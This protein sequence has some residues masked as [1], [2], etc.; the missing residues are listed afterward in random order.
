MKSVSVSNTPSGA[1]TIVE[2]DLVIVGSGAGGLSAAI[3]AKKHGLDVV[4]IE[5]ED[6]FGGTT[7]LSGGVLWIPG[8]AHGKKAGIQDSLEEARTYM[9]NETGAFFDQKA[10]DV[11]L[12]NGPEMVDFFE[13]ETCVK[14]IPTLYP[15]YHPN[16]G[17]GVD[18]GRSIL[19]EPFDIR[20]L[21]ADMK[22][23]RPPLKTITFI[24]MMFNSSNADLK[25][26]FQATKSLRSALYV[27]KRLVSHMR[28]LMLYGRGTKVTSGNALAARLAKAALDLGIPIY[29]STPAKALLK[30][31]KLVVGVK[32]F[33]SGEAALKG[34]IL[35]KARSGV[36][37]ACG[38]F[39]QDKKRIETIYPHLTQGGE[40]FSPTPAG[41]CGDGIALAEAVGGKFEARFKQA[42]AWMP[43][44]KVPYADGSFGA[45]PHL[46]DRYKPGVIGVLR[47]GRRFTNESN[48]YHDVGEAMIA[49]CEKLDGTSGETAMWL[50]CDQPTIKKY[51]LGYAKPAPVPLRGLIKRG[52]LV[53]GGSLA[54][55]AA[56][57]G[58]DAQ[59]LEATV[60]QYNLGAVKGEDPE[61]GRGTTT[62]NRYLADAS[63]QPNPCVAPIAQGPFYALK[64]VMGDLGTF[65]GLRTSAMG[66]VLDENSQVIAGLYAVGNDRESVMGGNYPAAGITLG[67]NMTFGYVTARHIA[68][69]GSY[70]KQELRRPEMSLVE[71]SDSYRD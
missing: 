71:R 65:D 1:V 22:R 37:L 31:G 17:G 35:F 60:H 28:E 7:A 27:A 9:R 30:D 70:V 29:T 67:P 53:K 69:I 54:E 11:F 18:I 4:V 52:Y 64:V 41:N 46:L 16:V 19:A 44:S 12:K 33:G 38:G 14:F 24:G 32:A 55:L 61:F 21:G 43:I 6:V 49:A 48:S 13:A 62:F 42:S 68:G 25:H 45:F 47:N 3:T 58:I 23:L 2:T 34:E 59:G 10:V 36:I 63:H 56:S 40:H 50:I 26:F 39:P 5:K 51:G 8:N 57:A 15:D 20:E 66:E